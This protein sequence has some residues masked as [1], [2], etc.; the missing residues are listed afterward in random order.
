MLATIVCLLMLQ[1]LSTTATWTAYQEYLSG[2][3]KHDVDAQEGHHGYGRRPRVTVEPTKPWR[4]VAK[5]KERDRICVVESHDDFTTDDTDFVVDALGECGGG[6]TVVFPRGR[7][8]VIGK[9]MDLSLKS[10]D[11]GTPAHLGSIVMMY[12]K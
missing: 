7:T 11:I 6:G 12:W 5:S 3:S 2:L 9:A 8:Y 10:V 4:Q 1:A